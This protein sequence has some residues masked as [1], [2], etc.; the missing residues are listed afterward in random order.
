MSTISVKVNLTRLHHG[1][2]M[3]KGETGM[4]ECI[5]LPIDK[6]KLTRGEKGIYIDF[7]GFELK[8]RKPDRKDTHILKQSV[9]KEEFE[10]MSDEEKKL[11]PIIGNMIVW[12]DVNAPRPM[13]FE[14]APQEEDVV[15]NDLPF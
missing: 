6:N 10:K 15:D 5:I 12:A 11:I 2:K 14:T 4:Q 1:I 9:S 3:M 13:N 7:T 8:E